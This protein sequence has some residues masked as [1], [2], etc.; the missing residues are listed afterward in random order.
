MAGPCYYIWFRKTTSTEP[1]VKQGQIV[2]S[3]FNKLM[4][5][6]AVA[7]A[8]ARNADYGVLQINKA[9][10]T[11]IEAYMIENNTCGKHVSD[12]EG[13]PVLNNGDPE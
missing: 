5:Y 13:T 3:H 8:H 4:D 2:G 12:P 11:A 1:N 10:Y 9:N 6:D 7:F